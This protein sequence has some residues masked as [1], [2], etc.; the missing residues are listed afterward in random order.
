MKIYL[1]LFRTECVDDELGLALSSNADEHRFKATELETVNGQLFKVVRASTPDQKAQ[2]K[3]T[4]LKNCK[5]LRICTFLNCP[6]FLEFLVEIYALPGL[7]SSEVFNDMAWVKSFLPVGRQREG[8]SIIAG[9]RLLSEHT[10]LIML[11]CD[12]I[13]G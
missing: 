12:L 9:V 3:V 1:P 10:T 2:A 13:F 5:D 11:T 7:R 6:E 8:R 4:L